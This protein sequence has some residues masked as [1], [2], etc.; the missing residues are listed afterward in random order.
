MIQYKNLSGTSGVY[1]YEIAP[2]SIT[3]LFTNG[4]YYLYNTSSTSLFNIEQM[5]RLAIAGSGLNSFIGKTV[6]D[7]YHSK[8]R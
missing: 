6:K 8:W 1:A 7:G 3:I 2:D 4:Y 5:K